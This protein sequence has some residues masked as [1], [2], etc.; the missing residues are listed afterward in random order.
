MA[1]T[2]LSGLSHMVSKEATVVAAGLVVDGDPVVAAGPVVDGGGIVTDGPDDNGGS[3]ASA[4]LVTSASLA[5]RTASV[6][7]AGQDVAGDPVA[8]AF[9]VVDGGCI[10]ADGPVNHGGSLATSSWGR[11]LDQSPGALE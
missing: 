2:S 11:D 1:P 8:A 3:L 9:V 5:F 7:A 10:V 6:G 4:L